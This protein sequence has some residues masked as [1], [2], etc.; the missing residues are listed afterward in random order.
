MLK[1][2]RT[3]DPSRNTKAT[4]GTVRRKTTRASAPWLFDKKPMKKAA[5]H[6]LLGSIG[7]RRFFVWGSE[8]ILIYCPAL[9]TQLVV[10]GRTWWKEEMEGSTW[11]L[12]R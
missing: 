12:R 4:M 5:F 10:E 1:P 7:S 2:V 6:L 9:V 8:I 11:E 3:G